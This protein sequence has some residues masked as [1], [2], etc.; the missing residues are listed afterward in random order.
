M[1]GRETLCCKSI[2]RTDGPFR[3]KVN[4]DATIRPIGARQLNPS[5]AKAGRATVQAIVARSKEDGEP[6]RAGWQP[7]VRDL[8]ARLRVP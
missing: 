7:Q 5:D 3:S 6:P 2:R 1:I 8:G 4:A